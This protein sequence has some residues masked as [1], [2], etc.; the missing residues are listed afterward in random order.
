LVATVTE[1]VPP[2]AGTSEPLL[3]KLTVQPAPDWLTAKLRPA[4]V[5]VSDRLPVLKFAD[6]LMLTL[7]VPLP[8][9]PDVTSSHEGLLLV[10]VHGQSASDELTAIVPLPPAAG[11]TTEAGLIVKAQ[12]DPNCVM[13]W[14]YPLTETVP[15]RAAVP[16][17]A[18]SE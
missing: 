4:T 3:D 2:L 1:P 14:V 6:T 16:G 9:D 8:L 13:V 17:F 5:T 18:E 12:L 15:D 11:I 7:P 10:A